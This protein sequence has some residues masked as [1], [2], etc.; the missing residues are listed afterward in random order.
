MKYRNVL[1]NTLFLVLISG[2]NQA[3]S[4]VLPSYK[5]DFEVIGWSDTTAYLGYYYG[6]STYIKDTAIVDTNGKFEFQN[7]GTLPHGV[8][9]LVLDKSKI[10][11]FLVG[12]DQH[13]S[14][15]T[16]TS[17]YILNMKVEG[18]I[19]NQ[20]FLD[21]M[22]FNVSMNAKAKPHLEMLNDSIANADDKEKARVALASLNA[23]VM[24][25]QQ[26]SIESNEGFLVSDLLKAQQKVEIPKELRENRQAGFLYYKEHF[27][28]NFDVTNDALI[29][30]PEPL[31]KNK[32]EE[33]LDNLFI[34]SPDTLIPAI[35][36]LITKAKT[37]AETY[38]FL[39]WNLTVK[40]QTPKYMGQDPI[41]IHLYDDYFATG[42]MDYWAN[43]SLKKNLKERADQLR[44]SQIGMKAP[45]MI[46]LDQN[47]IR[48]SL[49]EVPNKFTVLYFYDPDCGHCKKETPKLD[50]FY[51][52]TKYDVEVFAVSADTSMA[53][54]KK[55]IK[56]FD[57]KWISVNGPRTVT[58][59]HNQLY[60]ANTTPTIYI[61]DEKKKIIAK[62]FPDSAKIEEFLDEYVKTGNTN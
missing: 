8:Y 46:M 32:V 38:K 25:Q 18:D 4:Q 30:L 2:L 47:L 49:Y 55:Y 20:T 13:F 41:F 31:Y 36:N 58:P 17:N 43:E 44:K 11:D 3:R 24:E 56:D 48:K 16:D 12:S 26:K 14:V 37:N 15:A 45:N 34:Q 33:Y 59:Q 61:L 62:K 51:K 21:N 23:E 52:S 1:L 5:I 60:D 42:E 10:F 19:N 29:R 7:E 22:K 28:D 35:D 39:V 40:Y 53:K 57:L 54:M 9:F 27:W 50:A 6:E